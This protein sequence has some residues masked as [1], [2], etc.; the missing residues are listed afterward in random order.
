MS[1]QECAEIFGPGGPVETGRDCRVVQVAGQDARRPEQPAPLQVADQRQVAQRELAEPQLV[2]LLE[3]L[4]AD[5]SLD[6]LWLGKFS[7]RDLP[8]I[9]DLQY[10]GLL[11]EPRV[12]PRY[13]DDPEAHARLARAAG[14]EDLGTLLEGPA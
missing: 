14:T 1:L 7:L 4:G 8:L 2:E 13:L 3:H 11:R 5:G 10:R 9:G 6:Q 12:L